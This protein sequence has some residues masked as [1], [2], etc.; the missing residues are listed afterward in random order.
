MTETVKRRYN[1]A[2]RQAQA[3]QNQQRVIDAAARLFAERGYT[4]TALTEVAAE[5]EVA[6]QTL[7]AAFGTKANLLK[8]AIDVALA[9]DHLPVPMM[10]RDFVQQMIAEPDP[11]Q[12][13]AIY[14]AHVRQVAERAGGLLVAAWTASASDPA[15][16]ELTIELDA[17]RMR[18]MTAAAS[19]IAAK[20]TQAGCL[21]VGITAGRHPRRSV[22]LQLAATVRP[23]PQRPRL[24][25][26]PL[27]VLADPL[28]DPDPARPAITT[29]AQIPQF[30][31]GSSA[32]PHFVRSRSTAALLGTQSPPR[33]L[34]RIS[35]PSSA[36]LFSVGA[37]RRWRI[38]DGHRRRTRRLVPGRPGSSAA[39]RPPAGE[40]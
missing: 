35:T 16:K 1:A 24:E 22:G 33:D 12:V 3:R 14:A 29:I 11:R 36:G 30:R 39:D 23:A 17:Q 28:L 7:Y 18:G 2:R 13:L 8:H 32:S 40:N 20:A 21:A 10:E 6:V 19:D 15:V 25:P 27:P 38:R 9:G 31:R 34:H 26:R 5:A 37:Q 4:A